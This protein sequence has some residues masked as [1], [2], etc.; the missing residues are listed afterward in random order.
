MKKFRSLFPLMT[1]ASFA[2][3]MFAACSDDSGTVPPPDPVPP[4]G[5]AVELAADGAQQT[6][7]IPVD[8]PWEATSSADW[9]QLSQM[10]GKGGESC[11]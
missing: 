10:G 5:D 1:T 9:L 11:R 3:M 4:V 2:V 8:E 6:I 7:S